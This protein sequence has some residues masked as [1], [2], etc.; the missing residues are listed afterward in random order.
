MRTARTGRDLLHRGTRVGVE[1]LAFGGQADLADLALEQ[2]DAEML[3]ERAHLPAHRAVRDVELDRGA[4]KTEMAR[5]HQEHA[6]RIE[7][8]KGAGLHV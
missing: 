4:R 8:R 7:R 1:L 3:L 6:Q 2:H 5:G